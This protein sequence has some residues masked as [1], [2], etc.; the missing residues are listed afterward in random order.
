MSLKDVTNRGW[1]PPIEKLMITA[2]E[3]EPEVPAGPVAQQLELRP[4]REGE[5]GTVSTPA[6]PDV[7]YSP[8]AFATILTRLAKGCEFMINNLDN[9]QGYEQVAY[10]ADLAET[11]QC[12]SIGY[13]AHHVLTES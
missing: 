3:P 6:Y 4:L 9:A 10:F 1:T 12:M 8:E 2:T 11:A 7:P 5:V 13:M